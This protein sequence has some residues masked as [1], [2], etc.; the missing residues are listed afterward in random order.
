MP[1]LRYESRAR[2]LCGAR[3][4]QHARGDGD[5]RVQREVDERGGAPAARVQSG[6]A[7]M[8][9][10]HKFRRTHTRVLQKRALHPEGVDALFGLSQVFI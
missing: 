10:A 8:K 4:E 6:V 3:G 5:V 2:A 7:C 1:G 9:W